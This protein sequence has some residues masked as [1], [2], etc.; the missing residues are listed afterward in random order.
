MKVIDLSK[1][2][3]GKFVR[4]RPKSIEA[5]WMLSEILVLDNRLNVFSGIR[6]ALLRLFGAKI[7]ANCLLVH[8][9]RVKFP[10]N[11]EMGD[12]VWIGEDVQLYNQ[13]KLKIGSNVCI[14]QGS[15]ITTGSHELFSTMNLKT[16][17]IIIEDGAWI[18]SRCVVQMGV[19]IGRNAVVTPISVV[20]KSLPAGG[21]YG[22]NPCRLIRPR[23]T[24]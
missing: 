15:F 18:S 9:L 5:L 3:P 24:E 6:V 20:H 14:S 13:D 10:W 7:G 4:T 23:S 1:A 12:N 11:L 17:P 19:T 22:G 16:S 8:P 2:G 21:I